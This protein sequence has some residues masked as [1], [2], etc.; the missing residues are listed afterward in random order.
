MPNTLIPTPD[1]LVGATGQPAFGRF[2]E[3]VAIINGR[4]TSLRTPMG[5]QASA[6]ARHF[7]YKQFQY[8]GIV[9]D[10]LL[11]GCALADTAWMALAFVYVFEPATGKLEEYT[12]RSPLSRAL[13]MSQSPCQGSSRFQQGKVDIQMGYGREGSS[14]IKTLS[15]DCPALQLQAQIVEP[16]SFQPMSLCT[17]TGINGWTYANKVAGVPVSGSLAWQQQHRDLATM[18]AFG[19]HDFSAGY[20]RRDTFWNWACMTGK[21]GDTAIGFNL[22]CGVNETS[23]TENCIWLDGQLEKVDTVHFEYQADDLLMPWSIHS[24]DGK[25]ALGF[26]PEGRHVEKLNLGIF[27]SNFNQIFGRFSGRL[28]TNDGRTLELEKQ[29]GFVEEQF[30]KW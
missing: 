5:G 1:A 25:V 13:A 29:Y 8:F 9:S 18:D 26:Q 7:H 27:A 28:Q 21:T 19:H 23:E 11:V 22:S 20:M 6:F 15:V 4:D 14:L 12:W 2:A 10:Q 24:S 30:A 17:R 3:T 16:D